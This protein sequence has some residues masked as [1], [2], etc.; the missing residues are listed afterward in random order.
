M[1]QYL[2]FLRHYLNLRAGQRPLFDVSVS[3]L[4]YALD[5]NLC[6]IIAGQ[7]HQLLHCLFIRHVFHWLKVQSRKC[8]QVFDLLVVTVDILVVRITFRACWIP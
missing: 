1:H 7:F 8:C 4:H 3:E 2:S 5:S 6:S